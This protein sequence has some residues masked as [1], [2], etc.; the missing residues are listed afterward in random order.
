MKHPTPPNLRLASIPSFRFPT[1]CQLQKSSGLPAMTVGHSLLPSVCRLARYQAISS[2]DRTYFMPTL[3]RADASHPRSSSCAPSEKMTRVRDRIEG[4]EGGGGQANVSQ[5][6]KGTGQH[7]QLYCHIVGSLGSH[8]AR[9]QC[10]IHG[11]TT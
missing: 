7:S 5:E 3:L 1:Q 6:C 9:T 2:R 11:D 10:H 4:G 8:A